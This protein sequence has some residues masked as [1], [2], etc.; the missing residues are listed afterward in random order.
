[1]DNLLSPDVAPVRADE[2]MDW[3]ALESWLKSNVPGLQGD[4]V[5]AQFHGGHANLTYCVRFGPRELVVRR[6]PLGKIA[7]G[8]HDMAREYR[9]LSGLAPYFDQ[10]PKAYAYCEDATVIGAPFIVMERC[11]GVIIRHSLPPEFE[12]SPSLPRDVS[13]ALVDAL[14][15]LQSV[16]VD[17]VG[18]GNRKRAAS[19]VERQLEGWNERWRLASGDVPD[20]AFDSVYKQL[21]D[22][23]P[24]TARICV[25]HNDL[26]LDNCLFDPNEPGRV[27]VML[28]WDMTTIGDPLIEFGTLLGY[29][30]EAGDSFDRAP[31][32]G[33]DMAAFP[34]RQEMVERYRAKGGRTANLSWYEAFAL[35]KHA[36]V[37]KQLHQRFA[38]GESQDARYAA[39]PEYIPSLI[40]GAR[41]LLQG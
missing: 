9:V 8:A 31:T 41:D 35:W 21:A 32:I 39:F 23:R 29:W 17:L 25:V 12:L 27:K 37:L 18:F 3:P 13:F 10:A 7:P 5:V 16:D 38:R 26:K 40:E 2:S 24:E 22:S 30:K 1:M 6:P 36:V 14:V 28:D 19:F 20:P 15:A 11:T 33:L 4:M 34:T